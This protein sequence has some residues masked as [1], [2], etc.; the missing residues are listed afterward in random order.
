MNRS[1]TISLLFTAYPRPSKVSHRSD[2]SSF[3]STFP[4]RLSC[5]HFHLGLDLRRHYPSSWLVN[6]AVCRTPTS[7]QAIL[8]VHG[9][10]ISKHCLI[11]AAVPHKYTYMSQRFSQLYVV[12]SVKVGRCGVARGDSGF[13]GRYRYIFCKSLSFIIVKSQ[14]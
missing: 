9:G 2:R 6:T 3:E 10:P 4:Y 5:W 13:R 12:T 8:C 14:V 11:E 7:W 1:G